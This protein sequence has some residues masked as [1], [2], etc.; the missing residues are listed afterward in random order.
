MLFQIYEKIFS[1][2]NKTKNKTKIEQQHAVTANVYNK[3]T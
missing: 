2:Q 1:Q 3:F